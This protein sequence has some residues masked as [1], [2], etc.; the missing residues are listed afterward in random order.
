MSET[1]VV[2]KMEGKSKI[3]HVVSRDIR[4]QYVI[5]EIGEFVNIW[6]TE[7]KNC[8]SRMALDRIVRTAADSCPKGD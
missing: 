2:W 5:Q 6:R 7:W 8:V 4:R 3:E 1:G